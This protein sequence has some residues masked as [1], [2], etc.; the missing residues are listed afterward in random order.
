MAGVGKAAGG[1]VGAG[2]KGREADV[3]KGGR[4]GVGINH[5]MNVEGARGDTDGIA[6][7][8][9]EGGLGRACI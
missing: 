3:I 8:V 2:R 4:G 7:G 5:E 1:V 9:K 6:D